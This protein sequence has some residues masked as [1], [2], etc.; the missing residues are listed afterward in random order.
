MTAPTMLSPEAVAVLLAVREEEWD[1]RVR[2]CAGALRELR[3]AGLLEQGA[4]ELPTLTPDGRRR[5]SRE[6]ARL[7]PRPLA[8]CQ[9]P[10]RRIHVMA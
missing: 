2:R 3:L 8:W 10:P 5:A 4:D 9:P 6:Q 1:V 7:S